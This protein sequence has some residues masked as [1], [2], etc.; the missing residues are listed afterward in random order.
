MG[1]MGGL[2]RVTAG[3]V[4]RGPGQ[5]WAEPRAGG[6]E[7]LTA[8]GGRKHTGASCPHSQSFSP[9]GRKSGAPRV[10]PPTPWQP[11]GQGD[12]PRDL[13]GTLSS[14]PPGES[15]TFAPE[16]GS[17]LAAAC[18]L[19]KHPEPQPDPRGVRS[20]E[21]QAPLLTLRLPAPPSR[22]PWPGSEVSGPRAGVGT[23]RW[24]LSPGR[25]RATAPR[26]GK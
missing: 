5:V 23:G 6:P 2:S 11:G 8:L 3:T 15:L 26:G 22:A 17:A 10:L 20:G 14:P 18:R 16:P 7:G 19:C 4:P 24:A 13:T 1:G 9:A 25:L 21:C 12:Q